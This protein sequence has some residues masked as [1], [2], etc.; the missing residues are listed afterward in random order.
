MALTQI[1]AQ[2]S[3]PEAKKS[4]L[5]TFASVLSMGN[6]VGDL[7]LEAYNVLNP[8]ADEN[9]LKIPGTTGGPTLQG[10][11]DP[12]KVG[13]IKSSWL[14]TYMNPKFGGK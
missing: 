1:N 11:P 5:D 12:S 6:K 2:G 3:G 4:K 7:G 9:T 8:K 13:T 14:D 10:T